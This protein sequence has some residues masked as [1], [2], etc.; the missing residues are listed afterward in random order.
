[1]FAGSSPKTFLLDI[2]GSGY[3]YGYT[4]GAPCIREK[5]LSIRNGL[6]HLCC[7]LSLARCGGV[8]F[9]NFNSL[10]FHYMP[11]TMKNYSTVNNS[12]CTVTSTHD[13]SSHSF[14]GNPFQDLAQFGFDLHACSIRYRRSRNSSGNTIT[15]VFNISGRVTTMGAN[16]YS[17]LILSLVNKQ[18]EYK[19][20]VSLSHKIK[21]ERNRQSWLEKHPEYLIN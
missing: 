8:A 20:Y 19:T 5:G 10:I 2:S 16:S 6:L 13:T 12:I 21:R 4:F 7:N 1:M 3:F 15:G 11:K 14:S 9:F 17:E 18:M